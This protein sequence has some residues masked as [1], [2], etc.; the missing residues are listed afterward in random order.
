MYPLIRLR[1]NRKAV[2][3]REL[4]AE[5]SLSVNDLVLPLF[6]VEGHNERQEIK[7]LCPVYIVYRSIK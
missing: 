2:W 3:L 7:R 4:I 1:R 5:S 6:V